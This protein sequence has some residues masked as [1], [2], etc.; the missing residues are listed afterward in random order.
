[1]LSKCFLTEAVKAQSCFA[2]RRH[3][4]PRGGQSRGRGSRRGACSGG[5]GHGLVSSGEGRKLSSAG[6]LSKGL[7]VTWVQDTSGPWTPGGLIAVAGI[8]LFRIRPCSPVIRSRPLGQ[9]LQSQML[10]KEQA[11]VTWVTVGLW[12]T[13]ELCLVQ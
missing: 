6:R 12:R 1:M 2:G 13:R 11:G 4:G 3:R 10:F 9:E 5:P 8:F 7:V